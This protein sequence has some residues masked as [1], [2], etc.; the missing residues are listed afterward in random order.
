MIYFEDSFATC[1]FYQRESGYRLICEGITENASNITVFPNKSDMNK[2]KAKFC[3]K[4]Y[5]D[6]ILCR[7]L[8]TKYA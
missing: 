2:H 1:P 6:C 5:G 7:A 8:L 4:C 3:R